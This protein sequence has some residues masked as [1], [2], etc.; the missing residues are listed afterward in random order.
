[1][2]MPLQYS[3]TEDPKDLG[4]RRGSNQRKLKRKLIKL[5]IAAR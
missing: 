3:D 1:M 2:E 4:T 5:S